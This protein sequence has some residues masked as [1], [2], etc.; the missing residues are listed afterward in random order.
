[1]SDLIDRSALMTFPNVRKVEI[2]FGM[3]PYLVVPVHA[4]NGAP[5]V[6]A[7]EVVRCRD[8]KHR[9]DPDVCPMLDEVYY[10]FE[11]ERYDATDDDGFCH[12]GEKMD[13]G[14]EDASD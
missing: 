9:G 8:C 14:A 7:V 2:G 5:A 12:M 3:P 1:M 13:G 6:D 10:G 11:T 4:I